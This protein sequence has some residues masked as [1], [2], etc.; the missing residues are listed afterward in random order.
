MVSRSGNSAELFRVCSDMWQA[1]VDAKDFHAAVAAGISAYV[2]L[3]ANGE[4]QLAQGALNLIYV[5]I[6][7]ITFSDE[8]SSDHACSFCGKSG[9]EVKLGAG[10]DAFICSECVALFHSTFN[11]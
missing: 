10:S 6:G 1:A 9:P 7:Q 2:V 4:A 8:N 11:K 5:A 3:H